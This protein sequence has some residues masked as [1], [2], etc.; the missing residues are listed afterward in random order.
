MKHLEKSQESDE[1]K[2]I[3]KLRKYGHVK[4]QQVMK[5]NKK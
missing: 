1:Q 2:H 4:P 5:Q 3:R